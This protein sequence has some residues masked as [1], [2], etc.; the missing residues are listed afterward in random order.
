MLRRPARDRVALAA[1]LVLPPAVCALLLPF[2]SWMSNTNAALVLVVVVVAV[3]VLGR[4]LAGA[5]AALSATVWFDFFLTRPYERFAITKSAD[6]ATA[7]LLL[8][9]GF[10]VSQLAA[11]TR[12]LKVIAITDD[13]YLAQIHHTARLV[14]TAAAPDAVIDQVRRQLVGLLGLNGCRFE[15]GT[16]I[17][18]PPRLLE[19]GSI[20]WGRRRW[21]ADRDGLPGQE[22]ELRVRR[23]GRFHGRFMLQGAPGAAPPLAAR[24]VAVTLA[25]QVGVA[26]ASVSPVRA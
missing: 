6:I 19:D 12:E 4:R 26:F 8:A 1:A 3:A 24:L 22:V 13:D 7:V 17:G 15:Y 20:T 10:A 21:D 14:E 5:L 11:R 2:R 25:N 23:G 18:H 16:L 9:V